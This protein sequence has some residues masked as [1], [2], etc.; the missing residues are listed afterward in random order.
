M[1]VLRDV[2]DGRWR[3]RKPIH[4]PN[5]RSVRISG[6]PAISTKI[7]AEAAEREHIQRVLSPSPEH[8]AKTEVPKFESF[9]EEFMSTYAKANNKPSEQVAKRSILSNHLI[10]AFGSLPLD[11]ITVQD[12]ERMKARMLAK[13]LSRKRVNNVLNVL[14][15]LFRYALELEIIGKQ[16]TIRTLKVAPCKVDFFSTDEVARLITAAASEPEWQ[17]A[18]MLAA[19]TGLRM[20]EL[21]ALEWGDVDLK[22]RLLTVMRSDWR[23][24]IGSPKGGRARKIP[25]TDRVAV[26]LKGHRHLRGK[27]VFCWEDGR[28]WTFV[29]MRA[30]LKRQEKR[31]GLRITGWHILR[32]T[33]CSHLA[34]KGAAPRAIQELAGHASISVTERYMHL[35]PTALTEAIALL[36][37]ATESQAEAR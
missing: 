14:N 9:A 12:V 22:A 5:G 27:L 28:R 10:P 7:A 35:A 3:Y 26:A 37:T 33:F 29:T 17:T 25:L 21:L 20:G 8:V 4:L 23:G 30:G 1:S 15:K 2:R 16:P 19:D 31:A 24:Q 18:I 32:H 36:E 11:Q 34:M 13:E 6:T